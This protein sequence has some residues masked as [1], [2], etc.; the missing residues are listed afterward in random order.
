[1]GSWLQ[2][3]IRTLYPQGVNTS[4]P[5]SPADTTRGASLGRSWPLWACFLALIPLALTSFRSSSVLLLPVPACLAVLALVL[6]AK[7]K[8]WQ[9]RLLAL[10][11]A[12]LLGAGTVAMYFASMG[13]PSGLNL[14]LILAPI[15]V[16]GSMVFAWYLQSDASPD[17]SSRSE[18]VSRILSLRWDRA[19]AFA[20][21]TLVI[22]LVVSTWAFGVSPKVATYT[23]LVASYSF[24]PLL[25]LS[26]VCAAPGRWGILLTGI[27]LAVL[28]VAA[29]WYVASTEV[30]IF[31]DH[32]LLW[33][34][35][36]SRFRDPGSWHILEEGL[37]SLP[38][39]LLTVGLF[40]GLPILARFLRR[41]KTRTT[42]LALLRVLALVIVSGSLFVR[43]SMAVSPVL[44]ER[45]LSNSSAPWSAVHDRAMKPRAIN[46]DA[47]VRVRSH[48]DAP[49][50]EPGPARP[51]D[52]LAGRYQGRSVV[53][54][55][56]ESQASTHIAGLG[57]GAFAHEPSAPHETELMKDGLLFTN[58]FASG[59]DTRSALWTVLTGLPPPM[60]SPAGVQRAPEAARVGRMPD[61]A[62]LGYRCDWIY[63]GEP[64][65]DNWDLLMSG[66]GVRWWIDGSESRDLSRDYWTSWG[67][68]DEALYRVTLERYRKTVETGQPTFIGVLTV[69]NHTPYSIPDSVEG[70][71]INKDHVGG[72]RYADYAMNQLI[73]GLRS[74][75]A[76]QQPIIFLTADT[77]YIENLRDVEPWGILALEG[78]RIPGLLLLPDGTLGGERFDGVFAHD[79]LL[80]LLYMLVA[81]EPDTEDGKFR[82]Y[83]REVTFAN[84]YQVLSPDAYFAS[85]DH[86]FAISSYW[87]LE[88]MREPQ[89]T[90][91]IGKAWEQYK[92]TDD[93]LWPPKPSPESTD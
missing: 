68:P 8:G 77:S 6:A 58:Y 64:Q 29:I 4:R 23:W 16:L 17:A 43:Q 83:H 87:G 55:I 10:D 61:F 26:L 22:T 28:E 14:G 33:E 88:E 62:S 75:P 40:A 20:L 74:L 9:R 12:A 46:W 50:W 59:F 19:L 93:E 54:L 11:L 89:P 25:A 92:K 48:F 86:W 39:A 30:V 31:Q 21:L 67:M 82:S 13:E 66:A 80:D 18:L 5:A 71:P 2:S 53:V 84:G 1:M 24:W 56:M 76:D 49:T 65:F 27:A 91:R 7:S 52:T 51:L 81:P 35:L 73:E 42:F 90:S 37:V 79:D 72:T 44:A 85:P 15:L 34:E 57:E 69:S 32:P 47:A 78:V 45:Y 63:A 3:P 70:Q 38:A 36:A 60:G 41:L